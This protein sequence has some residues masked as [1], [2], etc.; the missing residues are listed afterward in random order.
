[1]KKQLTTDDVRKIILDV[2]SYL[3]D[4]KKRW[5]AEKPQTSGWVSLPKDIIVKGTMFLLSSTDEMIQFVEGLIPE[6]KDKKETVMLVSG[7]LFDY[8]IIANLPMVMR[9][10]SGIAKKIVVDVI[11]SQMID[12]MVQKYR[13]G[14]W[15]MEAN[16]EG[17]S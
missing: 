5:D 8:I 14:Y 1:M 7:K 3:S 13:S 17:N 11:V 15:K 12:F 4:L 6:G 2:E 16:E 10:F 9:P